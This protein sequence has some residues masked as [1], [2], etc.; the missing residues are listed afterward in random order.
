MAKPLE[1][2]IIGITLANHDNLIFELENAKLL[3]GNVFVL[4]DSKNGVSSYV[5]Y[6]NFRIFCDELIHK[7]LKK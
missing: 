3:D 2:A 6:R 4:I 5:G 1:E 7:Y